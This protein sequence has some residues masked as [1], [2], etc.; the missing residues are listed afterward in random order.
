MT[1]KRLP[2]SQVV[3]ARTDF[4]LCLLSP[5]ILE[6]HDSTS[7]VS[8]ASADLHYCML[9]DK[10]LAIHADLQEKLTVLRLGYQWPLQVVLVQRPKDR[11][12]WWSV[13]M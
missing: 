12:G 7:K 6:R 1:G 9:Y 5:T 3:A 10:V 11:R 2:I 4:L 8:P 13:H